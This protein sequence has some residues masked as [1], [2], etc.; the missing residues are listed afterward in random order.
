MRQELKEELE[1]TASTIRELADQ[2]EAM[3]KTASDQKRLLEAVGYCEVLEKEGHLVDDGSSI[4]ERATALLEREDYQKLASIAERGG[5]KYKGA[6]C[7]STRSD[8][9]ANLDAMD[10]GVLLGYGADDQ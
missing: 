10:R 6:S 7:D 8:S 2:Y 4:V 3:S 1:K 5:R 9:Y